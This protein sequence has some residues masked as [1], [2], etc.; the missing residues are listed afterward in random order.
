MYLIIKTQLQIV[1]ASL[2]A[3]SNKKELAQTETDKNGQG[4]SNPSIVTACQV[5][6]CDLLPEKVPHSDQ[7]VQVTTK[8]EKK[9]ALFT[10]GTQ[11][12]PAQEPQKAPLSNQSTQS[13]VLIVLSSATQSEQVALRTAA[14]DNLAQ[15]VE[16]LRHAGLIKSPEEEAAE[17]NLKKS[18]SSQNEGLLA[19]LAAF[20]SENSVLSEKVILFFHF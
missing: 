7:S 10:Q 6:Q 5:T 11:F 16:Y 18:L 19:Q 4:P 14:C 3:V 12:D 9:P 8:T 2:S 17:A 15:D 13:D 20:K 1:L